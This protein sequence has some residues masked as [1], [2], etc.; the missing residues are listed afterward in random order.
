MSA[1]SDVPVVREVPPPNATPVPRLITAIFASGFGAMLAL[2][3]PLQLLLTLHLI[4]IAD[5]DAEAA[6]GIVTG[7]GALVGL[8]ANPLGGRISD[9]TAA[10]FGRRRTWILTGSVVGAGVLVALAYTTEVWQVVVIWSA[11]CAAVNFQLAATS[12][13]MADQVPQAR[14]GAASG[15]I[16]LAAALAPLVGI[17]AVSM[18]GDPILQW[19][20][21]AVISVVIA[22]VAVALLRDPQHPRS[23]N[24]SDGIAELL[25]TFWLNPR[26]HPA[27]GWAWAVRFLLMCGYAAGSY[28]AFFLIGRFGVAPEDVSGQVLLLS[29]LTVVFLAVTSVAGGFLSDKAGRQKPFVIAS[30]TLGAAGLVAM[31]FAPDLLTLY[32]ASAVVG[33]GTGLFLSVDTAMCV[34]ML[35]NSENAGKDLAIINIANTLPQSLV[36]FLAPFLLSLGGYAVLYVTLAVVSLFGAAAVL[37]LP[38]IGREGDPRWAVITRGDKQPVAGAAG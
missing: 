31:A 8:I 18:I 16:G 26:K 37:R 4:R 19:I 27:F 35:P 21:L 13:L 30:G 11:A 22:I 2:S 1:V 5:S 36:P 25:R 28:S 14:R 32:I 3:T 17:L 34:R 24:G 33:A 9:R 7:F 23:P 38:E 6:L 12:A 15:F 20:T 10:R 29:L